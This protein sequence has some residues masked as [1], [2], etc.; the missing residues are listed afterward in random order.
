MSIGIEVIMVFVT[1]HETLWKS[2]D[3][4]FSLGTVL[5]SGYNTPRMK[6]S[7]GNTK[8]EAVSTTNAESINLNSSILSLKAL[9]SRNHH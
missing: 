6:F 2:N 7:L 8:P 9:L 4:R 1:D 5:P 3:M